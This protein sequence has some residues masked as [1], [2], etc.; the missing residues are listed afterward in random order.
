M[1]RGGFARAAL[2]TVLA[3]SALQMIVFACG[4]LVVRMLPVPQYASYT[5]LTAALGTLAALSDAGVTNTV[6]AAAGRQH[7]DRSRIAA[8]VQAGLRFRMKIGVLVAAILSPVLLW[9]LLENG[10][11]ATLAVAGVI[12]VLTAFFPAVSASLLEVPLKLDQ[13]LGRLQTIQLETAIARAGLVV[14]AVVAIPLGAV[15]VWASALA[16]LWGTWRLRLTLRGLQLRAAIPDAPTEQALRRSA[17]RTIPGAIYYALSSQLTVWLLAVLGTT[18]SVAEIGALGRLAMIFTVL[19]AAASLVVMPRFSLL[20]SDWPPLR[21]FHARVIGGLLAC[22]VA[23]TFAVSRFPGEILWLLG[24]PYQELRSEVVL[25]TAS[26]VLGLAVGV[27]MAL[28]GARAYFP[29]GYLYPLLGLTHM[30][31]LLFIFDVSTVRGVLW[32]QIVLSSFSLF[33]SIVVFRYYARRVHEPVSPH[34]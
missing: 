34:P 26:A 28:N 7:P 2:Q 15:A 17:W 14:A 20:P 8:I 6:M 31:P 3:Q 29:P 24:S 18:R 23:I 33:Y 21:D 4:V 22:G 12:A 9:M 25:M 30:F 11:G 10:D 1:R 13:R 32:M 19:Y 27:S 16:Q 5:L